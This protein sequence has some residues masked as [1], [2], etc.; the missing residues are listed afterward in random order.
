MRPCPSNRLHAFGARQGTTADTQGRL[1]LQLANLQDSLARAWPVWPL[2]W[3]PSDRRAIN[4]WECLAIWLLRGVEGT[5]SRAV[6]ARRRWRGAAM[7]H[8]CYGRRPLWLDD[9]A[10][11]LSY[12]RGE[13]P[14]ASG[15]RAFIRRR[16]P[17]STAGACCALERGCHVYRRFKHAA[18]RGACPFGVSARLWPA[19]DDD[20][21]S[22]IARGK[23][24][25]P[26]DRLGAF[27]AR[28][29]GARA[30][31]P[32]LAGRAVQ[33]AGVGQR[34]ARFAGLGRRDL[35]VACLPGKLPAPAVALSTAL[36]AAGRGPAFV[37][38]CSPQRSSNFITTSSRRFG[39]D[40][41]FGR[42]AR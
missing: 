29:V 15:Y 5:A 42:A 19:D 37:K 10:C 16:Q 22:V 35:L 23:A 13:I 9:A 17:C 38:K 7:E 41:R 32:W 27:N 36:P 28:G 18:S 6:D 3:P 4:I 21:W 8:E 1:T 31:G 40:S 25:R 12:R 33:V 14:Y 2:H 26:R 20:A 24:A 30:A 11:R 34:S 39:A